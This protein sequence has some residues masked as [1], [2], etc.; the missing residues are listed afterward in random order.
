MGVVNVTP[1]SFF[2]D[3]RVPQPAQAVELALALCE[4]G[5]DLLDIG[6]QST[7]PG[8]EPVPVS[9]EM[10]RV[11]PV[12]EAVAAKVKIPISVD[13]D[14]AEVAQAALEAGAAILN[15]VSA[16]RGDPKMMQAAL[17]YPLVVLM[18][19]GGESPKTMQENPSYK[20]VVRE[21][22][23]FLARRRQ[24]FLHAGGNPSQVLIDP[25]IGFGKNLAH[26]LSLIK[27]VDQLAELAPVVLGVSRKSFLGRILSPDGRNVPG[28]EQ[29]LEGSL[30]VSCL[31]ALAGV[32]VLRVHDVAATRKTLITLAAV[33]DAA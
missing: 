4:E 26:N 2:P 31:A 25:G 8:S 27:H 10:R 5:A 15:D 24:A 20:D 29:R 19:M 13:T 12:I 3:S 21:V 32:R 14:K 18:H 1:D 28:P 23:D 7:R 22:K 9:E 17:D 11:I 16:L 6:G 33:Q 30:A